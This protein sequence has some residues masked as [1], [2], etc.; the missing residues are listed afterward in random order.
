[1]KENFQIPHD[2]IDRIKDSA[3][4]VEVIEEDITLKRSGA[5]YKGLCPF[6]KDK[7]P[8]LSVSP[9][10]G[11]Y[12][13]FVCGEG[14]D[15]FS[16]LVKHRQMTF[17]EA[18]RALGEKYG[19]K[20]PEVEL[21][22]EEKI[23]RTEQGAMRAVIN[24]AQS[25][26]VES[27]RMQEAQEYT[28]QRGINAESIDRF[29]IGY[30]RYGIVNE[31][32]KK[33]FNQEYI[34]KVGLTNDNLSDF[35]NK[36]LMFPFYNR[37]GEIIGWTGRGINNEIKPKYKNTGETP[38]FTKGN[39]LYGFFQ[40]KKSAAQEDKIFVV[41][42]QMDVLSMAQVGVTNVVAGS[43]TAFTDAQRKMLKSVTMNVT[44]IYDGDKAGIAAA[45]KNLRPM[46]EEGFKVRCVALPVG[47]DPDDMARSLKDKTK[48]W[49]MK[50]ETSY[51]KF[52][53][54]VVF[55]EEQDEYERQASAQSIIKIIAH[56]DAVIQQA[57][58]SELTQYSKYDLQA[59]QGMCESL[60]KVEVKEV[61]EDGFHGID[62][63]KA[64]LD[65]EYPVLRLSNE[66]QK[67]FD[68]INK[69]QPFIYYKG[70]PTNQQ[71]LD[72]VKVCENVTFE[73]Y[74]FEIDKR[75]E[76]ADVRLMKE[77]FKHGAN[78]TVYE[79]E[80]NE[81]SFLNYYIRLYADCIKGE[82][83]SE[84][85]REY[86]LRVAEM[87]SYAKETV[88][89]ISMEDWAKAL[90]L[91]TSA[92]KEI[93]K[94]YINERKSREKI[95]KHSG[96][97]VAG[98]RIDTQSIPDY[99]EESEEYKEMLDTV[100]YYPVITDEG[101]PVCYM[102]RQQNSSFKRVA[103]FYMEP[104]LHIYS[105][106]KEENKRIIR[107]NHMNGMRKYVEWPSTVF[108]N[109]RSIRE[110]LIVE[111]KYNFVNGTASDWENIWSWSSYGFVQCLELR[112]YGQQTE[113]F[114]AFTN[115][116]F[117]KVE[118]EWVLD[119]ADELG[120]TEHQG[121]KYYSPAASKINT[122]V[123]QDEQEFEQEQ[124]FVYVDTPQKDRIT[125]EEWATLMRDVY[126]VNNNGMWAIVY[127]LLCAFRSDIHP[128]ARY[129]T[130]LFFTG[131]TDSGKTQVA[132]STR[133][134]YVKSDAKCANLNNT[135]DSAFFSLLEKFRDVPVVFEEYNDNQISDQKF[136]G[137]KSMI[138]DGD[139]KQKRKSAT[140]NDVT[141]SKP[142]S[143]IILLGQ[144]APQKDDGALCNR[145]VMLDVPRKK[146]TQEETDLF[147]RLK[148]YEKKGLTYLLL[149]V[150][151]LR[152]LVQIY[153][154]K[155]LEQTEKE[156]KLEMNVINELG[157]MNRLV[158]TVS[159]FVTMVKF[160]KQYAEHL[161]LPFTLEEFKAIAK[162]KIN[163]QSALI[164]KSDKLAVF[165]STID[166][167]IDSGQIIN[168][169]DFK[170]LVPKNG[171]IRTKDGEV[172]VGETR[173][174]YMNLSNVHAKYIK[175]AS[176][177]GEHPLTLMTLDSNL[178]SHASYIGQ[179]KGTRFEWYEAEEM[180]VGMAND[181]TV[182]QYA[183]VNMSVTRE[184]V[185]KSKANTSAVVLNY[186]V[187]ESMMSVSYIREEKDVVDE[188]K[189]ENL[190]NN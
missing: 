22:D 18:V 104:I 84:V 13:C 137:L 66:F 109:L 188:R 176:S 102:F 167:L 178:K 57:F 59:L 99:V 47:N 43:G 153:F 61:M 94:P 151:K 48:D 171:T 2:V 86:Y 159:L 30:A 76:N 158:R 131:P 122:N 155:M 16:W 106:K 173:C 63:A 31:L 19:V 140:T 29:G 11:C 50:S 169:R 150:L 105:K 141:A 145:V 83:N 82:Q 38:M 33:G 88:R 166:M 164:T 87:I 75:G 60:P 139:G 165:F 116:I 90:S 8:S 174:L 190:N 162:K 187:L 1:M 51:V 40:A 4:I 55:T 127:A 154:C 129:F 17:S 71:I 14:G 9:A 175:H 89:T 110:M 39:N 3:N 160:M 56:E 69:E 156:M 44:F 181:Q 35:F 20:V 5:N 24:A 81:P 119:L 65:K 115:A 15:A 180:A 10:R 100:G 144:E 6:H 21:T 92:L 42:G 125:F 93:I 170:I 185:K 138:Y 148:N 12:K 58:L 46:V 157:D 97:L 124:N 142:N 163:E 45:M 36:R 53:S 78:V 70:M 177:N 135:S 147:N 77:L 54:S 126:K 128:I 112:T 184:M 79:G 25:L 111:G 136:Q 103:D 80:D 49:L 168:G 179:V 96:K 101:V 74:D 95:E 132:V 91:K 27:L 52:L 72:L 34:K 146:F 130:S 28:K 85:T 118:D 32:I 41:E 183:K 114:F 189:D 134:L 108:A 23:K 68:K 73:Y 186:D 152:P 117:H 64:H 113:G 107:L 26:F 143:P 7:T 98:L 121:E 120:I 67:F 149:D 123:R 37:R 133:S 161:V 172:A 182:S 62:E